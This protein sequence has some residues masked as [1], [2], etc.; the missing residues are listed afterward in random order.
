MKKCQKIISF[1][2]FYP[3]LLDSISSLTI[4]KNQHIFSRCSILCVFP[5]EKNV[6]WCYSKSLLEN[7]K[8]SL[9]VTARPEKTSFSQYLTQFVQHDT[10]SHISYLV[11]LKYNF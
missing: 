8:M 11:K 1:G 5:P 2:R 6:R 9:G 3:F 7:A 4:L 10:R